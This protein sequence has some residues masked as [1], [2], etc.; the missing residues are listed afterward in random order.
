[1]PSKTWETRG[2]ISFNSLQT[3]KSFRT[4][5]ENAVETGN[6]GNVSIPFKRESPF[7]PPNQGHFATPPNMFQFPSNGKVLSDSPQFQPSPAVAPYT[8]NQTRTARGF[9]SAKILPKI[10]TNPCNHWTKRDFLTKLALKPRV[11]W[12][13]G[14]FM[15]LSDVID[16]SRLFLLIIHKIEKN[17]KFFCNFFWKCSVVGLARGRKPA[18]YEVGRISGIVEVPYRLCYERRHSLTGNHATHGYG[19]IHKLYLH[20]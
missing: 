12:V 7:G 20:L 19:T 15:P 5:N 6:G 17:V 18:P 2:F 3:G 11:T 1:M 4:E 8:Q 13:L 9:F 16:E 10:P 14:Q